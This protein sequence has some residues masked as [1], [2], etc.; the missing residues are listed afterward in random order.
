M[1]EALSGPA[2]RQRFDVK[3]INLNGVNFRLTQTGSL[4]VAISEVGDNKLR[5]VGVRTMLPIQLTARSSR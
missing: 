1:S 2:P 3:E 5:P 4:E